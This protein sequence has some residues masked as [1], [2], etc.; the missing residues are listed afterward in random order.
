MSTGQVARGV[1]KAE[2]LSA[3]LE[4]LTVHGSAGLTIEGLAR[5][6][7]IARAG[8]Y[9]HFKNR[10]DL[11]R[12]M[13]EFWVDE[14]T[15]VVTSSAALSATEPRERL[16][17][18]AEMVLE[19]D[20]GRYDMAIRQWAKHDAVAARVVRR[21]NRLRLDF[22]REALGE[23]GFSGDDLEMRAMLFVCYHTWELSMFPDIPRRRLRALIAGR[24]RLLTDG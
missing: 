19:R 6:L 17:R 14:A 8:F 11:L 16:I 22:A 1:S 5:S 13:L 7:G 4:A 20:L 15:E 21:V 9:W 2:W 3:G 24:L 12:Q 10:D 18:A 23:L